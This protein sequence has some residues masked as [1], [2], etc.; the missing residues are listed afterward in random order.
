MFWVRYRLEYLRNWKKAAEAVAK[1]VQ[2][3]EPSA[4]V[5]VIGG[6]QRIG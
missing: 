4:L 6:L 3:L 5:Y 1:A 2:D